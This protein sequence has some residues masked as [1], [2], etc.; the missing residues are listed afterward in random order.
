MGHECD[1]E[2]SWP[3]SCYLTCW[4]EDKKV[5]ELKERFQTH[6]TRCFDGLVGGTMTLTNSIPTEDDDS[7]KKEYLEFSAWFMEENVG[8]LNRASL[9]KTMLCFIMDELERNRVCLD[10]DM[11]MQ[12]LRIHETW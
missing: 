3:L 9:F 12:E 11:D 6:L 7:W 4:G 2:L 10:A 8:D 1:V 5:E